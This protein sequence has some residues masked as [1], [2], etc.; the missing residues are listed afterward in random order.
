MAGFLA[1]IGA[2]VAS[3]FVPGLISKIGSTAVG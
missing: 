3:S 1:R 2:S